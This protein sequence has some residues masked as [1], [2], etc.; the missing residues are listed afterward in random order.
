[1]FW[2]G[3]IGGYLLG[4]IMWTLILLLYILKIARC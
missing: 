1:M 3:F 4:G 2:L